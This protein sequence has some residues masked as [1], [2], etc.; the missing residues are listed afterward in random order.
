MPPLI[1]VIEDD[2]SILALYDE[3]LTMEG[4]TVA[5]YADLIPAL[6]DLEYVHPD[7]IILDWLFGAGVLG[8]GGAGLGGWA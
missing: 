1:L 8:I 6:A 4:Y 3:A 5:L 7:L 2:P